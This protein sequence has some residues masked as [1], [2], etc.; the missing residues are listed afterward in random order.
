MLTHNVTPAENLSSLKIE[1]KNV[2][3]VDYE[4]QKFPL[5][6]NDT[7]VSKDQ[8]VYIKNKLDDD[9]IF[10]S[11][12][13]NEKLNNFKVATNNSIGEIKTD[14]SQLN[15]SRIIDFDKLL[16]LIISEHQ[17]RIHSDN[18]LQCE[19]E[20]YV[21]ASTLETVKTMDE[22]TSGFAKV[23]QKELEEIKSTAFDRTKDLILEFN[24]KIKASV[25]ELD[26]IYIGNNFRI[27][28]SDFLEPDVLPIQVKNPQGNWENIPVVTKD[29]NN[30][31]SSKNLIIIL[32]LILLISVIIGVTLIIIFCNNYFKLFI[33]LSI[34][35]ILSILSIY[36]IKIINKSSLFQKIS[37]FIEKLDL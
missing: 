22:V 4:A 35:M 29:T 12:K 3:V 33:S 25:A 37:N 2:R 28:E 15:N 14:V 34:I 20:K 30:K 10:V 36:I 16:N 24:K 1:A 21:D 9:I 26:Q 18:H 6:S 23:I 7:L 8:I 31:K 5:I 17:Q 32:G 11:D 27:V 19:I 13:L